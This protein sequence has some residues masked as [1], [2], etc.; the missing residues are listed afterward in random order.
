MEKPIRK[1]LSVNKMLDFWNGNTIMEGK[2]ENKVVPWKWKVGSEKKK[3]MDMKNPP[4]AFWKK[5]YEE[6]DFCID[7]Q[8]IHHYCCSRIAHGTTLF[9]KYTEAVLSCMWKVSRYKT[10]S[11]LNI[12]YTNHIIAVWCKN[13]K[14]RVLWKESYMFVLV[15][16]R[17]DA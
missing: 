10:N 1:K 14:E 9:C 5:T 15:R 16:V 13:N 12:W 2:K 17:L 3:E 8:L 6:F 11:V 7:F 4:Q